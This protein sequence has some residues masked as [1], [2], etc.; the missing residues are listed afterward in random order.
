M[1]LFESALMDKPSIEYPWC[2][3][4]GRPATQRHHIVYR[5][6]GGTDGPTVTVCGLGNAS[7]RHGKLHSHILHLRYTDRWE[8]LETP[9]P[10]KE[11][12]ALFMDGW[13]PLGGRP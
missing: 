5:S 2:A 10:V 11:D 9:E 7:G 3:F 13:K 4:C 1:N 8:Y 12:R 6:H